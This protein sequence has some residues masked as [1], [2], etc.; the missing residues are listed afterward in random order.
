MKRSRGGDLPGDLLSAAL[1]A[2]D[3]PEPA[4]TPT[5]IIDRDRGLVD[6]ESVAEFRAFDVAFRVRPMVSPIFPSTVHDDDAAK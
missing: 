4:P 1:S 5:P 3:A 6:P 2:G